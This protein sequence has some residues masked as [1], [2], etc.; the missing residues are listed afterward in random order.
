MAKNRHENEDIKKE[1]CDCKD[2]KCEE[3][4]NQ[5]QHCNCDDDCHC[6]DNEC[7]CEEKNENPAINYLEVAQR[8]QA[9]FENYK[10]RTKDVES[11]AYNNGII[12]AVRNLLP[13]ID[14]FNQA[15]ENIKDENI[16]KGLNNIYKLIF[17]ALEKLGVKAIECVGKK[18]DPNFHNAVVAIEDNHYESGVVLEEFQQGFMLG[19]VV[20]RHSVVKIN[21]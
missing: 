2:C 20:I 3:D 21:K 1:H 7:H 8:I 6:E 13:V 15:K 18:F 19:D 10:R 17:T 12:N 16:L 14:G 4:I 9:E 11:T 5:H